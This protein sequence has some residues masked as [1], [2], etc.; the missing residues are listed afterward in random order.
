MRN[1]HYWNKCYYLNSKKRS[2]AEW[3]LD[4]KLRKTIDEALVVD[5]RLKDRINLSIKKQTSF[6][7]K[8]D[9][10]VW[11]NYISDANSETSK[12]TFAVNTDSADKDINAL[13][14]T[15]SHIFANLNLKSEKSLHSYAL[16][17]F[18]ILDNDS[19]THVC[20][21]SMKHRFRKTRESDVRLMFEIITFEIETYNE[22]DISIDVSKDKKWRIILINVIYVLNFMTNL[23]AQRILRAKK[24]YLNEENMI[25]RHLDKS[26]CYIKHMHEHD[27]LKDNT[28][29]EE[30]NVALYT[31][32]CAISDDW[33]E[34]MTHASNEII[35]H[36]ETVAKK[37]KITKI[38]HL[39]ISNTNENEKIEDTKII[40]TFKDV[41]KDDVFKTHECE[42]Y[43]LAK[44][45][46]LVSRSF[47]KEETFDESFFRVTYDLMSLSK[48]LNEH[49]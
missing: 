26:I 5:S 28:I 11:E 13:F 3:R 1:D 22:I 44:V 29:N 9:E 14:A 21:K 49:K 48:G 18:W 6:E 47:A 20:N 7:Q 2:H 8:R 17:W 35:Q 34:I 40:D 37:M 27:V 4:S 24:W 38:K 12:A 42:L 23:I 46:R 15:F 36:L 19:N 25:I 16:H 32:K 43:A 39:E 45:H 41:F 33:H 31:T 10:K 30:M